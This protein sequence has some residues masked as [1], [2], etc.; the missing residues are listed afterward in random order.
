MKFYELINTVN[1]DDLRRFY[2]LDVN[3]AQRFQKVHPQFSI[4]ER[5]TVD[6]LVEENGV[7][8][9]YRGAVAT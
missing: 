5:E 2:F 8:T 4:F 7:I 1:T 3:I 6:E 9:Q